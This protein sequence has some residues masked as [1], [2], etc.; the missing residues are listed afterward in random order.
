MA[1]SWRARRLVATT[2]SPRSLGMATP[3][4][5]LGAC[6]GC[7]ACPSVPRGRSL[8]TD[9]RT[10]A[11][12]STPERAVRSRAEPPPDRESRRQGR[13]RDADED[14]HRHHEPG[15]PEIDP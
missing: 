8:R 3:Y 7:W 9:G 14:E 1:Y 13:Q 10:A 2:F 15:I 11:F 12:Q 6:A 5:L 4:R